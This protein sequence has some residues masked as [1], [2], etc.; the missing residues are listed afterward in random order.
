MNTLGDRVKALRKAKGLQQSELAAIVGTSKAMVSFIETGRNNPTIDLLSA[1][2]SFFGVPAD[3]LLHGNE[4]QAIT[5]IERELLGL[6]RN[7]A[8][9]LKSLTDILN[10]KKNVLNSFM[11]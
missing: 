4:Q 3:Y 8:G 10:A 7:D 6:I 2:S 1:L 11:V 5:P 9:L